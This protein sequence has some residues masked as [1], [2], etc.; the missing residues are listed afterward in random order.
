[1]SRNL[2][3]IDELIGVY[4]ADGGIVGELRYITGKIVGRAHCALCD[5]THRGLTPRAEWSQACERITTPFTLLHLNERPDDVRLASEG[6]APC[7]LARVGDDLVMLLGPDDLD[8]C[9]EAGRRVRAP[10]PRLGRPPR[11]DHRLN[12]DRTKGDER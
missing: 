11:N 9:W 4:N 10:A 8:S 1:M 5:I 6:A 7:V 12:R 2:R 3:S